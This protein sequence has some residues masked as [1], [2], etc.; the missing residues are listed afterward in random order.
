MENK[1]INEIE[2]VQIHF[3]KLMKK[4]I[5]DIQ[6]QDKIM[7]RADKRQKDEYD[8]LQQKLEEVQELQVAQKNLMD[9]FIKLI[10]SAIDAKSAYTGGHCER[11]PEI[12]IM[13]AKEVSK[14]EN[15]DFSINSEDE[16]R[17]I[18]IAAWLHDC[19]KVVTPEY[20]VDKATKLETIYNRIH[21]IRTRFEV[22]HRDLTIEALNKK[23]NGE[24]AEE[25][26]KWLTKEHQ[27]LQ[28]EFEFIA[29][30][31]VGSEFMSDED[32]EKIKI[33][34]QREWIRHFDDKIGLSRGELENLPAQKFEEVLPVKEK[35][36]N[37]KL[38]H[39]IPRDEKEL[40]DFEKYNFKVEIP[41]NLYNRGEIYNLSIKR[42]TLTPEEFFKIQEHVM[43]TIKMLEQLPFPPN[44]K[45]VPLYAGAHH[46]T[47]IGTGYPRKLTKKDLPIPARI[48]AIADVFEALTAS[49]RP[50]KEPKKLSEAIKILSF[51]VKDGHLDKDL[52]KLFLKSGIYLQYANEHLKPEQI[53]G[54]DIHKY[55]EM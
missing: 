45:N 50:Y 40:K 37:D 1:L 6:R 30:T 33:I 42:G 22:I 24:N 9:S 10:A 12:A 19:G 54:V 20:V 43:M 11:V 52:F 32:I 15:I 49:D 39:I 14:D 28:E 44:L 51:M 18:S 35:L 2:S 5:K 21:E 31:N 4:L 55:S 34:A 17:E 41:K 48:M 8:A 47:L 36:L 53:D 46:E 38:E 23:L 3:D 13:L 25:V 26:D 27:K 7:I 16:E 29:K